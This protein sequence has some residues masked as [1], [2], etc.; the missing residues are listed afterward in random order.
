MVWV[1]RDLTDQLVPPPP[2]MDRDTFHQTRVLKAPSDLALDTAREGTAT[3]PL[4]NCSSASP[5]S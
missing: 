2:A 1:G 4:G 5:P 3:A